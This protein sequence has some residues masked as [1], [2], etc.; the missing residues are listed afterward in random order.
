M[1]RKI[2]KELLEWKEKNIE[3]PM[4]VIGARQVGKTNFVR[5]NL[6]NMCI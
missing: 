2:Y 1:E 4:M 5:V 3:M 6:R